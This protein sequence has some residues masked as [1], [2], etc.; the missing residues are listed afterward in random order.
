MIACLEEIAW[1]KG[2]INSDDLKRLAE[3]MRGSEYGEYM[4]RLANQK[5]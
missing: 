3:P 5:R 2:W 1:R 4:M